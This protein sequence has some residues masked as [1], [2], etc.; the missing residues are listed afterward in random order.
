[1]IPP[2][3]ANVISPGPVNSCWPLANVVGFIAPVSMVG[4]PRIPT[5]FISSVFNLDSGTTDDPTKGAIASE[6]S[7]SYR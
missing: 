1:M 3:A 5:G 2:F 4:V 6:P 7:S